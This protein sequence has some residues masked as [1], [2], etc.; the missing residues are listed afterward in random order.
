MSILKPVLILAIL[1]TSLLCSDALATDPPPRVGA[2]KPVLGRQG[3]ARGPGR[4]R[5]APSQTA[6]RAPDH[7]WHAGARRP[8]RAGRA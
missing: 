1:S 4:A 7:R 3:C 6:R 2:D 5:Q 8:A